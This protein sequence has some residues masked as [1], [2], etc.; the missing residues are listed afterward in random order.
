MIFG[1]GLGNEP[2]EFLA[3]GEDPDPRVRA[4][5][6][7][8]GLSLLDAIWRGEPVDFEGSHYRYHLAAAPMRPV[9]QPRVP[10]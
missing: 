10:V 5:R 2:G 3:I 9:Q 1:A 4:V 8:E 7:D 6:L